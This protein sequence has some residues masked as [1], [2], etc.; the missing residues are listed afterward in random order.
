MDPKSTID[1]WVKALTDKV[2]EIENTGP[3]EHGSF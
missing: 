3:C 1:D 2:T